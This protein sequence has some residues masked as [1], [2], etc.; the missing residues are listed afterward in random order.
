MPDATTPPTLLCKRWFL[1]GAILASCLKLLLVSHRE[2]LDFGW[3]PIGYLGNAGAWY[4]GGEWTMFSHMRM[5]TFP[6]LIAT[7]T[8]LG[9]PL[10]L[11]TEALLI[12]AAAV[13]ARAAFACGLSRVS[14]L[15]V[16][17]GVLLEPWTFRQFDTVVPDPMYACFAVM[18]VAQAA[19]VVEALR[20]SLPR[21]G[22]VLW[23]VAW[24]AFFAAMAGTVRQETPVLFAPLGAAFACVVAS[25]WLEH[26]RWRSLISKRTL[27]GALALL[28]A[29]M[30]GLKCLT[31]AY[32]WAN[33]RDIGLFHPT[34]F[35]S[36]GYAKLHKALLSIPPTLGPFDPR[37]QVPLDV[38]LRA[39]EASP[40]LRQLEPWLEGQGLRQVGPQ[41]KDVSPDRDEW[42]AWLVFGLRESG[43]KLKKWSTAGE[44]DA[45]F[46]Q[47]ARELRDAQ[48][49]GQLPRRW[50]PVSFVAPE[51]AG[52]REQISISARESWGLV[53]GGPEIFARFYSREIGTH[54]INMYDHVALRRQ[55]LARLNR[56]KGE[57]D[58]AVQ[59]THWHGPRVR[60]FMD[61]AWQRIMSTRAAI[62]TWTWWLVPAWCGFL[63]WRSWKRRALSPMFVLLAIIGTLAAARFAV[64][65][66]LD[67][68]GVW[69]QTRYLLSFVILARLALTICMLAMIESAVSALWKRIRTGDRWARI[70]H[71]LKSLRRP[72]SSLES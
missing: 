65:A 50:T 70:K 2:I 68:S 34:D 60:Q 69:T 59:L 52:L 20:R 67:A 3:D 14:S 28:V 43:F 58:S 10:R 33:Y 72:A 40:T 7:S 36:P 55:G 12:G 61:Q 31:L 62:F 71:A 53:T 11:F 6:L 38:R 8:A 54:E 32:S 37:V 46:A 5:P 35:L 41:T 39:Y 21:V 4:W 23:P 25:Q 27:A 26:R 45:F 22:P 9:L 16:F 64:V 47:A 30:L 24:L 66:L 13:A 29:P 49:R 18:L 57:S 17:V 51:W 63:A 56:L 44:M 42:G 15:L 1:V 48:D 19:I